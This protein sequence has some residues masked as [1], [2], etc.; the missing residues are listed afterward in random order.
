M[1]GNKTLV[2]VGAFVRVSYHRDRKV[3]KAMMNTTMPHMQAE[4]M[5]MLKD[6]ASVLETWFLDRDKK[7]GI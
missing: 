3:M 6:L 1:R 7:L 2:H 5:V 4:T